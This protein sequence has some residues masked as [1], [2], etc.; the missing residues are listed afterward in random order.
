[1]DLFIL[2]TSFFQSA[3]FLHHINQRKKFPRHVYNMCIVYTVYRQTL[4]ESS[5]I[6]EKTSRYP[7]VQYIESKIHKKVV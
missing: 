5:L 2:I 4:Y 3:S 7:M 1:M 6:Q